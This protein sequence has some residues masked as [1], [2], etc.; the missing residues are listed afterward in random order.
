MTV[1]TQAGTPNILLV[2][3]DDLGEGSITITGAG[4]TRAIAVHSIDINLVD[5]VGGLPNVSRFLRNGLYFSQAWAQPACSPTRASIYTGLHPW[6]D[7]VGS[8]VGTPQLDSGAGFT[9]LPNL[10]PADYVSGLFG[11]WHLGGVAGTRPTDHGWDKFV[12]TL[13]GVLPDFYNWSIVDSD[14][15]YVPVNLDAV[16]NPNDYATLRTVNEAAAWI[17]GLAPDVPWFATVAFHSPHDPYHVPPG[18]YD[19]ATAGDPAP[20]D[21]SNPD[22]YDYMFNIMTQNVDTNIGRLLG[23]VGLAGGS[24]YF[25]PIPEDQLSNTIII[26]IG[27]NGSYTQVSLEESKMEIGEGGVRIPMI[28]ADGQAVVNEING[29]AVTPRFLH[30]SRLNATSPLMV[31]VVDLYKTIVKL[32][33]PAANAF[34]SDTDS[35]DYSGVVKNPL[36]TLPQPPI[37]PGGPVGGVGGVTPHP[38]GGAL[39][40]IIVQVPIRAFNFSQIYDVTGTRATIRNTAYK[41]DYDD[42]AVPEYALYKYVNGEIPNREDDG[43]ATDLFSAALNGTDV[44]AQAN[45][46]VLLDELI[47]NYRRDETNGF[48]DPR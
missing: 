25:D 23:T 24:R 10:L 3:T 18:G 27:D 42:G 32:V 35:K 43:T 7:G 16:A 22:H 4:I 12:G 1:A 44:D 20:A 9:T 19:R 37:G 6:K 15:G 48:P 17:N 28:V 46:N 38:P 21:P 41:L 36:R 45:L 31:H 30:R 8:P 11:K 13:G 40:P 33:D 47:A 39:P 34:P 29:Q 14:T 26:F 2:I 5:I